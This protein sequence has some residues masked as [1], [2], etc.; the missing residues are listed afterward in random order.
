MARKKMT[1]REALMRSAHTLFSGEGYER[2]GVAK[3]L[4]L[5]KVQAPTLYHHFGDKEGLYV[6]WVTGAL[7]LTEARLSALTDPS[8]PSSAALQAIAM[9]LVKLDFDLRQVLFD[10][11]RL[12][13][14][15]SRERVLSAYLQAIY[16]PLY[17]V[18]SRGQT[19]G[20][21]RPDTVRALAE[22]FVGG[23]LA[24]GRIWRLADSS[25]EAAAWYTKLFLEGA[26]AAK[27][28]PG[29]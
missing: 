2:V 24:Q 7:A 20:E 18:F 26:G 6:E 23:A 16:S 21:I 22:S 28:A 25:G 9:Q 17:T 12:V 4:S 29:P 27:E 11:E 10:G 14:P 13:R 3:V 15:E 8:L 1:G 5:A 19:K